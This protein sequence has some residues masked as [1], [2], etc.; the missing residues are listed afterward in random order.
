MNPGKV[1]L[2]Y[3]G[4]SSGDKN[5]PVFDYI[6]SAKLF[7]ND[8]SESCLIFEIQYPEFPY[9]G[10]VYFNLISVLLPE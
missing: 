1:L 7:K 9:N 4:D 10:E 8:L 3:L 2:R 6:L 5:L